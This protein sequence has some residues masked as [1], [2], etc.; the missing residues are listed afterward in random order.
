MGLKILWAFYFMAIRIPRPLWERFLNYRIS[1]P[2]WQSRKAS[3]WSFMLRYP[4]LVIGRVIAPDVDIWGDRRG[5]TLEMPTHFS[6]KWLCRGK[7]YLDADDK[8]VGGLNGEIFIEILGFGFAFRFEQPTKI[9]K[10]Y[11]NKR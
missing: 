4:K 8:M 2:F 10:R 5:L 7:K 11:E 1:D 9:I 6:I 3:M